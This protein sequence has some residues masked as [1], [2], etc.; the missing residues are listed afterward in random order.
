MKILIYSYNYHPEPIGIAPLMT[1][2]AE[3]LVRRGHSVRV[4]TGMPNYPQRRIYDDYR[5]KLYVTE[6]QNGVKIQRCYVWVRPKPGFMDRVLLESSF[7]LSSFVKAVSGWKPDV[8]LLTSP[9]LPACVP[10]TLLKWIRGC[11]VVLNLQ[12]VLPEAA[13]VTGLLRNK[14]LIRVFE[15][16]ERFAYR[17][18]DRISAIADGFVD[19]LLEKGVD[20]KKIALIPNW[21]DTDFIRPLPNKN[22]TFRAE[23]DLEG[24]FVVL[25]SGNIALTQGL[26]TLIRAASFLLDAPDIA[27]I[28]VGEG[29]ALDVLKKRREI[30]GATNVTLLPFQPRERLPEMLSAA[31]VGMVMQKSNVI[32]INMPSKIQ[33]LLASGLPIIASVPEDGTAAKAVQNSGG[34]VVVPPESPQSVAAAIRHLYENPREVEALG[35][36]ARQF[37]LENYAFEQALDRYERLFVELVR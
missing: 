4:V 24:K 19:N 7:V 20:P 13:I 3:G 23:H 27:V 26:E 6:A 8:I 22:N 31:N 34:G 18:A 17:H 33:V 30:W 9:P 14:L 5:G 15:G 36:R 37:A 11:P 28:I 1:E 29:R 32:A 16:L 10:A 12:D 21:V 35:Q 25:Y 2:L